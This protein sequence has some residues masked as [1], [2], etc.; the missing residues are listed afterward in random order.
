M[1]TPSNFVDSTRLRELSPTVRLSAQSANLR[2]MNH[3]FGL[4]RV[5]GKVRVLRP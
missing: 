1:L 5:Q 3:E 4:I 2:T